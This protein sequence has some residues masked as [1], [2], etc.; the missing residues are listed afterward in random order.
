MSA[1]LAATDFVPPQRWRLPLLALAGAVLALLL[2]YRDTV[3]SMTGIWSRSETFAHCWLV[4]PISLWLAWRRR[5]HLVGLTPRPAAWPLLPLALLAFA[6]MVGDLASVNALTHFAVVAMLV[7]TV[8]AVLGTAVARQLSFPLAFLLFMVPV[9]EFL[10]DPMMEWTADF[11]VAAIR[12]SGIPVYR[13][14]LQFVIPSGTWSVVEACSGVR[15]LIASFMVGSLFA[16]LNY[17]SLRR[18]LVFCAVSLLVPLVANWLRAYM[19]V[20]LGHLS[21]NKLAVG[22]DH[23]IYGWVFFGVVIGIMFV[24]GARWTEPPEAEPDAGATRAAAAAGMPA[25]PTAWAGALVLWLAVLAAPHLLKLGLHSADSTRPLAALTLPSLPGTEPLAQPLLLEPVFVN[26]DATAGQRLRVGDAEVTLHLG[27]YRAQRYGAKLV[28]S[29]NALIKSESNDW[30]LLQRRL[31]P[32]AAGNRWLQQDVLS[33][34]ASVGATQRQRLEVLQIYWIDGRLTAQP[35][36]AKAWAVQS[37]LSGRGDAGALITLYTAGEPAQTQA[38]LQAFV[39]QHLGAI[40]RHLQAYRD[41]A[42]QR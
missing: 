11:T 35:L 27:F 19:I 4:L 28:S 6:W 16:Y 8:P 29:E 5:P 42:A 7:L 3:L 41:A 24:I 9:G 15:Y 34:S 33:G 32:D 40:E 14:G 1:V 39:Q 12:L 26:P 31:L 18:R 36:Q 30:Q 17:T 10:L 20:M 13:E 2:L 25:A 22:V 37:R 38:R 21:G 23:L